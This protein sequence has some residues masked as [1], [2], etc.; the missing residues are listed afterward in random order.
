MSN[1][2]H[3]KPDTRE[4]VLK[5]ARELGYSPNPLAQAMLSG[6]T[7]TLGV[8]LSDVGNPFFAHAL[9]SITATARSAGYDIILANTDENAEIEISAVQLMLDKRVDGIILSSANPIVF[10]HL[11]RAAG[12]VPMVLIDRKVTAPGLDTVIVDNFAAAFDATS[13]LLELGH[14][15]IAV[16]TSGPSERDNAPL[17]SSI[18]ERFDGVRAALRA[19]GISPRP[20]DFWV[21]GWDLP[22]NAD[23]V[24]RFTHD[25]PSAILATDSLVALSTIAAARKAGLRIP[26]D[27][28]I[29]TFDNSPWGEAFAPAL[30]VVSQPVR[31]LGAAATR[32][33]IERIEG[34]SEPPREVRLPGRL[35]VRESSTRFGGPLSEAEPV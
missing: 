35:I 11:E 9:R 30:S 7:H 8:V 34:L 3:V 12:L 29:V 32:M 4:K 27:L 16:A 13:H 6:R 20:E 24:A 33:V 17:I 1:Q 15:R 19:A 22:V 2:A 21:G 26:D 23:A 31:E 18:I 14:T 5:A 25:P 10:Q 28:S